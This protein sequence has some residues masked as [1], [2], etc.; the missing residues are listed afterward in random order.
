MAGSDK[1]RDLNNFIEKDWMEVAN[2]LVDDPE[3]TRFIRPPIGN[4]E[5]QWART[6]AQCPV[7]SEC[8]AWADRL[9]VSGVYVAGEWRE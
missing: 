2:C 8:L 3:D 5:E 9:D 1:K 6:C 4:E 7:F